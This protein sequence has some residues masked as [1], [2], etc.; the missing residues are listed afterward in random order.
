MGGWENELHR[1]GRNR[2]KNI[3]SAFGDLLHHSEISSGRME[4][5]DVSREEG[6]GFG[7]QRQ[8]GFG[9]QCWEGPLCWEWLSQAEGDNT[10]GSPET[11]VSCPLLAAVPWMM[12]DC[13]GP[14][15][16]KGGD[17]MLTF[18]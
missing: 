9:T 15:G 2:P 6:S 18:S 12:E 7:F 8:L 5:E 16:V 10:H 1:L 4:G 13:S 11:H 3:S 17:P 14:W